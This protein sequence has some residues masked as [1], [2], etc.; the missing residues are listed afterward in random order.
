MVRSESEYYYED[1]NDFLA[2]NQESSGN[3]WSKLGKKGKIGNHVRLP[4]TVE[5]SPKGKSGKSSAMKCLQENKKKPFV[6]FATQSNEKCQFADHPPA[7]SKSCQ[8]NSV[9]DSTSCDKTAF[10]SADFASFNSTNNMIHNDGAIENLFDYFSDGFLSSEPK[11]ATEV[12]SNFITSI[13]SRRSK[14]SKPRSF[15]SSSDPKVQVKSKRSS[16]ATPAFSLNDLAGE[17]SNIRDPGESFSFATFADFPEEKGTKSVHS[18][19]TDPQPITIEKHKR[20]QSIKNVKKSSL[21]TPDFFATDFIDEFAKDDHGPSCK[22]FDTAFPDVPHVTEHPKPLPTNSKRASLPKKSIGKV[23]I[24]PTEEWWNIPPASDSPIDVMIKSDCL[25][26]GTNQDRIP[27]FF[28]SI[29]SLPL[30]SEH[31]KKIF[32]EYRRLSKTVSNSFDSLESDAWRPFSDPADFHFSGSCRSLESIRKNEPV[33]LPPN[34][35]DIIG[36][37][38][39]SRRSALSRLKSKTDGIRM[40]KEANQVS[41][42]TEKK[43]ASEQPPGILSLGNL[44]EMDG[45]RST[46][47][48]NQGF[49]PDYH[50]LLP[51]VSSSTLDSSDEETE[52]TG[53]TAS[54]DIS[55]SESSESRKERLLANVETRVKPWGDNDSVKSHSGSS[56]SYSKCCSPSLS[57]KT[58][59]HLNCLRYHLH[60]RSRSTTE[61]STDSQLDLKQEWISVPD[62]VFVKLSS[63]RSRGSGT[64][65]FDSEF[66]EEEFISDLHSTQPDLPSSKKTGNKNTKSSP[67]RV[68]KAKIILQPSSHDTST[69]DFSRNKVFKKS[70]I[71]R[72]HTI[73]EANNHQQ[74]LHSF[75]DSKLASAFLLAKKENEDNR[76]STTSSSLTRTNSESMINDFFTGDPTLDEIYEI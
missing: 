58:S 38:D 63:R 76:V 43:I 60:R 46:L 73:S 54:Q 71:Q 31:P 30:E 72:R 42:G 67:S 36:A 15:C 62:N 56:V 68:E 70:S 1:E 11:Q 22:A 24:L 40:S 64:R 52:K 51:V 50:R 10:F 19:S 21:N 44:G 49:T 33:A 39:S 4:N 20:R 37:A 75:L 47:S 16:T 53:K 2:A 59:E 66:S 35:H 9:K 8:P 17:N 23:D 65:V 3:Y 34:G 6:V 41:I 32:S 28:S 69:A 5:K 61:S 14:S 18:T 26:Y 27:D 48:D 13:E 55:T 45:F 29:D 7:R 57:E 25:S 12:S 74:T